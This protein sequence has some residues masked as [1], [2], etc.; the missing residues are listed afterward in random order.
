M[1][2]LLKQYKSYLSIEQNLSDNS[3]DAYVRDV[4]R[5]LDYLKRI[6]ISHPAEAR[7][8]HV[9][10]L[11][12]L[13]SEMGLHSSSLA[14]NISSVSGFYRYLIGEN[15]VEHDPTQNVDRPK[16]SRKLPSVLTYDE[17]KKI[18]NVPDTRDNLG[19]RN[20]AML[21][22]LYAAGLRI[23]E[24]LNL[25]VMDIYF[26]EQ[27]MRVY[28]KGRKERLTPISENALQWIDTYLDRSRPYLDRRGKGGGFLFLNVRGTPMSR[29]GFWKIMHKCLQ[30][31]DIKKEIHPHTFRHSFA[32]HLL[33]NGADLRAVQ[34]MLGHADIS[35]TQ[36]Y[37][38]LD[39][40][41]LQQ[42]YRT[43][44]PRG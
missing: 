7:P 19:L 26:D 5:Y 32:T 13:L 28:G 40:S 34:E 14:R 6:G 30:E 4:N 38:H 37:T 29:M 2:P 27:I 24:L 16:T 25:N 20:R 43:F 9:H 33:E 17:I 39:R 35:T 41:Y 36:I 21:E 1:H 10:R 18:V 44:H 8:K 22:T 31:V 15:F 42:E 12:Q 3:I 11:I 23:S